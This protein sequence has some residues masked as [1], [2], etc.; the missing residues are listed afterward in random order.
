MFLLQNLAGWDLFCK[1]LD[2]SESALCKAT[3]MFNPLV[4]NS[5]VPET[6]MIFRH[7]LY[8]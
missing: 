1:P 5:D 3:M 7:T 4:T 8:R 2:A 6:A